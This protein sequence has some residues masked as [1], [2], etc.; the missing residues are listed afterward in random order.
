MS[1]RPRVKPDS[2][3]SNRLQSLLD[4]FVSEQNNVRNGVLLV[5]GPGFKWEGAGG[6]AVPEDGLPMLSDDQFNIDSIAKMMTATIV[7]KLVEARKLGVDD[8]ISQYLPDLDLPRI[9]SA[10]LSRTDL[11]CTQDMDACFCENH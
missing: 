7:M 9:V 6:M 4:G 11:A 2:E 5:E 10:I 8:R 3:L 1:S